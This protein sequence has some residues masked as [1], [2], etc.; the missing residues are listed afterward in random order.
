MCD[1]VTAALP[2]QPDDDIENDH[3]EA[4]N[5]DIENDNKNKQDNPEDSDYENEK[6]ENSEKKLKEE[7]FRKEKRKKEKYFIYKIFSRFFVNDLWF[8]SSQVEKPYY[9]TGICF[10][11]RNSE[12]TK[13]AK[14]E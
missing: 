3:E 6:S 5:Q 9:L 10:K 1:L 4:D 2:K 11:C 12:I 7:K 13:V 8:C 14:S